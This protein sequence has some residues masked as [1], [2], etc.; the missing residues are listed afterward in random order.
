MQVERAMCSFTELSSVSLN[1]VQLPKIAS[2]TVGSLIDDC[3][4]H[5]TSTKV[6]LLI[7]F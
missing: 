6:K 5:F 7:I 4:K 1:K 3:S 2:D